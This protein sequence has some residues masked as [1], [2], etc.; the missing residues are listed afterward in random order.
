MLFKLSVIVLRP[1]FP[2]V[3]P[4]HFENYIVYILLYIK[5]LK[6]R[7]LFKKKRKKLTRIC[8]CKVHIALLSFQ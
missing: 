4:G 1:F 6:L 8:V 5:N 2:L 7:P 3:T